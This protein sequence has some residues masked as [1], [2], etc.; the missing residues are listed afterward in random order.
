MKVGKLTTKHKGWPLYK[1]GWT[2]CYF[3]LIDIG[4]EYV[5]GKL[6]DYTLN[7]DLGIHKYLKNSCDWYEFVDIEKF[8][9]IVPTTD[10][11]IKYE[12]RNGTN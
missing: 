12:N 1:E 7:K 6:I 2:S 3:I 8:I 9:K 4:T 11:E 10:Q 5:F